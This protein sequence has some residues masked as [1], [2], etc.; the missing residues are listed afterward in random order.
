VAC[1]GDAVPE[2]R[3]QAEAAALSLLS[4]DASEVSALLRRGA[5]K[6]KKKD[7]SL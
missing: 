3:A 5:L 4:E 2:R 1:E 6:S 7:A